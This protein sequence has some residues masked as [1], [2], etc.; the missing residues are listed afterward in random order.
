MG[1]SCCPVLHFS[2]ALFP[3]ASLPPAC[4]PPP[5]SRH[6][7]PCG[8]TKSSM[9][10]RVI[11]RKDG[12][13]VRLF[14]RPGNDP[15]ARFPLIVEAVAR[16]RPRSCIVDGE[17]VSCGEDGIASFDRIRYRL[18]MRSHF[19]AIAAFNRKRCVALGIEHYEWMAMDVHGTCDVAR[20]NGGKVFSYTNPPPDGHVCEGLCNSPDWCRCIARSIIPSLE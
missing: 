1:G 11:A 9:T 17:A 14:S 2:P 6:P 18:A 13:R 8:C 19:A 5:R 10:V 20:K 15:T 12:T 16:L 4:P 3:P 7:A